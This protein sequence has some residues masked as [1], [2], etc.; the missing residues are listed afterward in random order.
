MA[1]KLED[2]GPAHARRLQE[3]RAGEVAEEVYTVNAI[4]AAVAQQRFLLAGTGALALAAA[5]NARAVVAN[6]AGSGRNVYLARLTVFSNAA[7]EA[8]LHINP[9]AGVPTGTARTHLNAIVGAAAGVAEIRA[10]TSTLTPLSG[11]VDTGVILAFGASDRVSVD[12][13]PLVLTPG[14]TL[15]INI[16]ISAAS[17]RTV[18]AVY[19]FEEDV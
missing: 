10:D 18:A 9:T 8:T 6:P 11:G 13:P 5:G 4:T 14:V 15:G 12:L 16:P 1:D 17:S 3:I 19:W 2:E 7:G